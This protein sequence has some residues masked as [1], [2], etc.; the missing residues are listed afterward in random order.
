MWSDRISAVR[1]TSLNHS[2]ERRL[3][4]SSLHMPRKG[5][6]FT[7]LIHGNQDII[8][9]RHKWRWDL[10]ARVRNNESARGRSV[11]RGSGWW[12]YHGNIHILKPRH[13]SSYHIS[14]KLDEKITSF[15]IMY[16]PRCF[17]SQ[18]IFLLTRYFPT[19]PNATA[20]LLRHHSPSPSRP[21]SVFSAAAQ[22]PEQN[23]DLTSLSAT[24]HSSRRRGDVWEVRRA[25]VARNYF[26]D[27]MAALC[28]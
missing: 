20:P 1:V 13:Q 2:S 25:D 23:N 3:V 28:L 10:S 27:F 17:T 5:A 24:T 21:V 26:V 8:K 6:N 12:I 7:S 22:P 11:V 9:G 18:I 15:A 14:S 16:I 4:L 19:N